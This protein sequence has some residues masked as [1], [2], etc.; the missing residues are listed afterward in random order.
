MYICQLLIFMSWSISTLVAISC[1]FSSL[2]PPPTTTEPHNHKG[3]ITTIKTWGEKYLVSIACAWAFV[4]IGI[5][6]M[7]YCGGSLVK[8]LK[9]FTKPSKDPN[10]VVV[11][12]NSD[13]SSDMYWELSE[14]QDLQKQ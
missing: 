13:T 10:S 3:H 9:D 7:A 4:Y 14:A 12:N 11:N 2:P 6:V 5:F 8:Y 1:F